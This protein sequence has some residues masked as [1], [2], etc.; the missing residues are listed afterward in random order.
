MV[1]VLTLLCL[2]AMPT[3]LAQADPGIL[4]VAP[5]GDCGSAN[6]C[7]STIQ[8]AVDAASPGDEIR[9]AAGV[10]TDMS[11]RPKNDITTTGVVT[12]VVYIS[13]TLTIYGGYTLS[14]WTTA[15][16]ISNPTTLDA[17]GQGRVL[18]ITGHISPVIEGLRITGGDALGLGGSDEQYCDLFLAG[19]GGGIYIITA[20]TTISNSE[21]FSNTGARCGGGLYLHRSPAKLYS[22]TIISNNSTGEY[23]MGG[24][25]YLYQSPAILQKNTIAS[26]TAREYGGGLLIMESTADLSENT[27][28]SNTVS[29]S[30]GSGGG[31]CL[32]GGAT[33]ISRNTVTANVARVG[34]G[35]YLLGGTGTLRGNT[36]MSNIAYEGGG[37]YTGSD[38]YTYEGNRVISNIATRGGGLY[39]GNSVALYG[40]VII[41]NS[42]DFGGGLYLHWSQSTMTNTIIADNRATTNGGG[43]Y[44]LSSSPRLLHTTIARNTSGD[45]SGIYVTN[46]ATAYSAVMLTNTILTSHTVGISV[47]G[48]NTVT[49][50]AVLWY[51][52]PVTVS[53]ATTA[54][55][56]MQNQHLGDPALVD[57]NEGNYHIGP[58]SAAADKGVDAGVYDDID[59][60]SRPS[61]AGYDLGADELLYPL[62]SFI[63]S[64]P[65][66][67]G[68]TT[69][70][71]NTTITSGTMIYLWSFG[72]GLTSTFAGPT[73]TYAY[74]GTFTVTLTATN[75]AGSGV[76]TGTVVV[77]GLAPTG[78]VALNDG[79]LYAS[80]PSVTL[81]LSASDDLSGVSEMVFSYDGVSFST[82][83]PYMSSKVWTLPVGDGVKAVYARFR[84]TVGNV[85]ATV[86]DTI[87]LDTAAPEGSIVINGGAAYAASP[88]ITLTLSASDAT[89]GLAQVQFSNDGSAWSGWETYTTTKAWALTSGDGL[90]TVYVQYSDNA[91]NISVFSDAI[92]LDTTPSDSAVDPLPA[93]Q[94]VPAFTV[95]WSGADALSGLAGFDVQYKDSVD[96]AWTDWLTDTTAT[97]ASFTGQDG[98]TYAFR[99]R[100]RDNTGNVSVYSSGDVHMT[101]D[102]TPP[103]GSLA[104]NGGALSTTAVDV[105]LGLL[106]ADITSGVAMMSFS[107]DG[108]VWDGWQAY[109]TSANWVL[110]SGDG[111]KTVYARFRDT[112]GNISSSVSNTIA[113]DTA[114]ETEY[115]VTINEGALFTNQTAVTLTISARPGTTQMQI[116]NDG[117]FAGAQ[118]EPYTSRKTWAITQYGSYVIPRVVHVRYKDL[119][120]NVS[121]NYQDDIILDVTPPTGSVEIVGAT[122]LQAMAST[123]TLKL[124]ATD[125]VSGVG[126]MLV[127]HQPDFA[128]ATWEA[129]ATSR[130]WTLGSSTTVYVRFRDNAGNISSTYSTSQWKVLLPLIIK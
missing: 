15:Y 17:Q 22:N 63:S 41:S 8:A 120:G 49:M 60:D 116:S 88:S 67:L 80:S 72:D 51:G 93:Y 70:F 74:S 38:A 124:S 4:F 32:A 14:N 55:V 119:G 39:I 103:T 7:Y 85:S 95:S 105:T 126:Q 48:G 118:W 13:K 125:D 64:S 9:I 35:L 82:F 36:I 18:Y 42:A 96:G 28:V 101:V 83:E 37:M 40:D 92:T 6:P 30:N 10:Y 58:G 20:T 21:V 130:A 109:A 44:L 77:D 43:L 1:S 94:T 31:L 78:T 25:L 53:Q 56:I 75:F 73:H 106:A 110:T 89:S 27:I 81:T 71:T 90:K 3:P 11:V 19:A 5:S 112:A 79:A 47:T 34:G 86:S 52:T 91:G 45:G 102:V 69:V 114:A 100:A 127:S 66:Q 122:R 104:I 33:T 121:S 62:P 107:N 99:V 129:Y 29:G 117:G 59:G 57:P 123:V 2:L 68:Q 46:F 50:N 16:P 24:G 115:G 113:L 84:D 108:S 23:A 111:L 98:Y 87:T 97:S 65:D 76:A 54:T 26:N 12:Q 61:G 128:G